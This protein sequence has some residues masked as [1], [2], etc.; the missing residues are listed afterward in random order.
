MMDLAHQY[1]YFEKTSYSALIEKLIKEQGQEVCRN[2]IG[3]DFIVN[4]TKEYDFGFIHKT[5]MAQI[6]KTR[7][8]KN[9]D[10]VSS[11]VFCKM[12]PDFGEIDVTL[13]CSRPTI[14]DGKLLMKWVKEK[15]VSL[16]YRYLSLL[17]IGD[18]KVMKWYQSIGFV[19]ISEKL[20]PDGVLKAYSMKKK[21]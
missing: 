15:A 10:R 5:P 6:G 4:K 21:L 20:Y 8:K 2:V 3:R 7:T 17:S 16:G 1:E 12:F 14:R 13:L 11:F 9:S 19:L 18:D